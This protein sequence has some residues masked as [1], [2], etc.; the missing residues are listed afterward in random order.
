MYLSS[1]LRLESPSRHTEKSHLEN[2]TEKLLTE[3]DC[4]KTSF[5]PHEDIAPSDITTIISGFP[6][7]CPL[8][9][10]PRVMPHQE[11]ICFKRASASLLLSSGPLGLLTACGTAVHPRCQQTHSRPA[12]RNS[13]VIQTEGTGSY[14]LCGFPAL[15]RSGLGVAG[16]E[17]V[18]SVHRGKCCL[19]F[20]AEL[21]WN[22]CFA[23]KVD[24]ATFTIMYTD[25]YTAVC[26]V[27]SLRQEGD[28]RALLDAVSLIFV[29]TGVLCGPGWRA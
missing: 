18:V 24:V 26:I 3:I 2:F 19:D 15:V 7:Q 28:G 6:P 11:L 4:D 8:S 13:A 27:W 9:L 25:Q 1:R 5:N 14:T 21:F 12:S 29:R 23:A 10:S 20:F 16:V 22:C 17:L